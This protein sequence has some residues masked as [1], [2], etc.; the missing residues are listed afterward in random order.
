MPHEIDQTTGQA[1]VFVA[2]EPP[3]HGLG[4]VVKHAATGSEALK[5]AHLDWPVEQWPLQAV[6][7]D[8]RRRVIANHV[9]NVRGDTHQVLGVVTRRYRVFQNAELFDFMDQLVGEQLAMYET[10]GALHKGRKVWLLA[11]I[12][13]EYRI[14]AA[15]RIEPYILLV[16]SHD[17]SG[18]LRVIPTTIR[19]V[20]QNTLNLALQTGEALG[21]SIRHYASLKGRVEAARQTLGIV[22]RRFQ[23]FEREL[24]TLVGKNVSAAW[25]DAYFKALL[26]PVREPDD[27]LR[28][29]RLLER[30]RENLDNPRNNLP[31]IG[32]TA[33]SA[34]NAVSEWSDH[35]RT[36]RGLDN[37]MRAERRLDSIWFG[38][39]DQFKQRAFSMA[40]ADPKLN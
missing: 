4:T 11:R 35:Q 15:D 3:W 37:R 12:P 20:C 32:S 7:G 16:N 40:L 1:A 2:G 22:S 17:G 25:V 5:L 29:N 21:E 19:V 39:S 18:A 6:H 14:S 38:A 23:V 28:Q 10:A 30:W 26:P 36:F 34:F 13:K 33:W 24:D 27:P 31:G 8:G 9:A